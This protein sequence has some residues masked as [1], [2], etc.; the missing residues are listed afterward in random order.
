MITSAKRAPL[1]QGRLLCSI[2][3]KWRSST[4]HQLILEMSWQEQSSW[5]RHLA[6][7]RPPTLWPLACWRWL[8]VAY[9]KPIQKLVFNVGFWVLLLAGVLIGMGLGAESPNMQKQLHAVLLDFTKAFYCVVHMRLLH[10]LQY[11]GI[12]GQNIAWILSFLQNW[13]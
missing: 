2:S 10:K 4:S 11:H 1:W 9:Q 3:M 8:I 5:H 7:Q 6:D 12:K 13:C